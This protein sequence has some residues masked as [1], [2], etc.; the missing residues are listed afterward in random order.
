[1]SGFVNHRKLVTQLTLSTIT[2]A[3]RSL[4]RVRYLVIYF[5]TNADPSATL[6]TRQGYNIKCFLL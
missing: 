1:M 2:G 6:L 4:N 5:I 3:F